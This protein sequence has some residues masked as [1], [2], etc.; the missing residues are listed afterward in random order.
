MTDIDGF[1]QQIRHFHRKRDQQRQRGLNDYNILTSVLDVSDEVRLH[2]RM[3]ASLLDPKGLHYQEGLFLEAFI[4][5][6][7]LA[8][9]NIQPEAC[10]VLREHEHIDIYITDGSKLFS[11]RTR[12]MPATRKPRSNGIS[13]KS[14]TSAE[15]RS[16]KT[17]LLFTSALIAQRRP[18][19][20]S[21]VCK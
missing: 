11:S 14:G 13:M 21:A 10:D 15:M 17:W 9:M 1:F 16:L 6:A 19:M 7:G 12:F 8:D 3:I 4:K 20:A 5:A 2:S 18:G